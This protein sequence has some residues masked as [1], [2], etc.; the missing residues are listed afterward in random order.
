MDLR[1]KKGRCCSVAQSCPTLCNHMNCSTPGFPVLHYLLEFAQ[2]HIHWIDD[3]IQPSH[4][5]SLPSHAFS[6]SQHQG[7]FHWVSSSHQMAKVWELQFQ[8][9]SFQW[10][11]R[12]DF[13]WI[14]WFALLA[15]QRT[16][17]SLFQHHNSKAII[18]RHSAFFTVQLS[19]P[20]MTT[21]KTIV[22]TR[23]T[24]V[25]KEDLFPLFNMLSRLVIALLPRSKCL[26]ISWPLWF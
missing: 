8:H 14:D 4:A 16:L 20:D 21:G 1:D 17:K 7:L 22:L 10:I 23:W 15:V 2:T 3:A 9:Q 11:F 25:C 26:L 6:L 5:L 18:L 19:H 12:V 24:F 13:L